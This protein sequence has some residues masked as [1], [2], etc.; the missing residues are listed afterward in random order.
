MPPEQDPHPTAAR[1]P[2][3]NEAPHVPSQEPGAGALQA[4][5]R[6]IAKGQR[7]GEAG[8]L[9]RDGGGGLAAAPGQADVSGVQS[10]LREARRQCR[11]RFPA[12]RFG[13]AWAFGHLRDVGLSRAGWSGEVLESRHH[14]PVSAFRFHVLPQ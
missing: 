14:T 8:L 4:V 6:R 13:G 9:E 12:V 2:P 5:C 1:S 3:R 7:Q 11:P 10:Q